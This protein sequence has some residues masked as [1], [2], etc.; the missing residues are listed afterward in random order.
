M[1]RYGRMC[2]EVWEYVVR[3]GRMCGEVW[4]NMV[5]YGWAGNQDCQMVNSIQCGGGTAHLQKHNS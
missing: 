3:Y 4:E 5:R 2:G 1:V